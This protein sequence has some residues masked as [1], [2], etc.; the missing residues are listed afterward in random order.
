MKRALLLFLCLA[1]ALPLCAC[2]K[3]GT[4]DGKITVVSAVFPA[5]DFVREIAKDKV[6]N[7]LLLSPGKDS[8]SY[9]PSA[10]DIINVEK[11]ELF[12]HTGG[13]SDAWVDTILASVGKSDDDVIAMTNLVTLCESE[14]D[15]EDHEH[16]SEHE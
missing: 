15:H 13:V 12:I 10:R 4:D 14:H 9:D 8:H 5:Y 6:N 3:G 7:V 2:A 11:C 1:I 16:E